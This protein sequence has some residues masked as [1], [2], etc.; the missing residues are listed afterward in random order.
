MNKGKI[1][2]KY[3]KNICLWII[4]ALLFYSGIQN[5]A[6]MEERSAAVIELYGTY[7][8]QKRAEEILASGAKAEEFTDLCFVWNGGM[9]DLQNPEYVR[10]TQVAVTGVLGKASLYDREGMALDE[11]DQ[12]GCIIDEKTAVELFGSRNCVGGAVV[13]NDKTYLVRQ[14]ASWN[15]HR[16]LIHPD[17]KDTIYT[18]VLVRPAKGQSKENA[19]SGILMSNGYFGTLVDDGW[20]ENLTSWFPA[21]FVLLAAFCIQGILG[22]LVK[23]SRY[24]RWILTAFLWGGCLFFLSGW[25]T[26]PYDW[27]PD[28]WSDFSFWPE[29][30]QKEMELFRWYVMLPKTAAQAER[31]CAGM[32]CMLKCAAATV[33]MLIADVW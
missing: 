12:E 11:N 25:I 15:M 2:F 4:A 3:W 1:N 17:A 30:I 10:Q 19:A 5:Y 16:I 13:L 31:L 28:K 32:G 7:P 23:G 24:L 8:D 22:R 14:A 20:L 26:F 9:T 18:Q 27:L 29:K 6:S 33:I 21:A